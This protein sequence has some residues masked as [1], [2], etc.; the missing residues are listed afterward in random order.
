MSLYNHVA[1]K[2][3]LL[4]AIAVRA[5]AADQANPLSHGALR[6]IDAMLGALLEAG[7]DRSPRPVSPLS[8]PSRRSNGSSAP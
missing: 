1:N 4:N 3:D 2:R 6:M 8:L 5:L 7:L